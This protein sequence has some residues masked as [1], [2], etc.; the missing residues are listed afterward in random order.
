MQE[1]V[2][3]AIIRYTQWDGSVPLYD[4]MCGS[5]TLLCELLM[6]YC[7]IPSG[8]FRKHFGFEFLPDYDKSVWTK[9]KKDLDRQMRELPEGL[10]SGSD[11]SSQAVKAAR[12]NIRRLPHGEKIKLETLDFRK[13][14]GLENGVIITNPPRFFKTEMQGLYSIYLFR[15]TRINQKAR[16]EGNMEKAFE[17]RRP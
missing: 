5:G 10:I 14:K 4:P 11:I 1:T 6:H 17:I 13:G 3:A 8:I 7:R 12:M 16:A 2:A 15:R 9:I